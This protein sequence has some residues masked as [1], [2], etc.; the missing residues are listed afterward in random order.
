M[1]TLSITSRELKEI[2]NFKVGNRY[3]MTITVDLNELSN[4]GPEE[5]I[6]GVF[7]V[8]E[9]SDVKKKKSPREMTRKEFLSKE[10]PSRLNN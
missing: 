5:E 3:K 1:G 6:F 10:I 2:E 8:V 9:A 4:Y 7:G